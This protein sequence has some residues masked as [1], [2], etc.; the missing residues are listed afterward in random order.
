M[1]FVGW[2]DAKVEIAGQCF[3]DMAVAGDE[4]LASD[5]TGLRRQ[6]LAQAPKRAAGAGNGC[7][8]SSPDK[9]L[10]LPGVW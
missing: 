1:R 8:D 4:N 6:P 5:R 2:G 7:S 3:H 10:P 9:K